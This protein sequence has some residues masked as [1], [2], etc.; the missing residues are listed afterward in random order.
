[1]KD[2]ILQIVPEAVIEDKTPLTVT[3]PATAFHEL[4]YRLRT[5]EDLQF[6][7]LVCMTGMDWGTP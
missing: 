6:D 4:A 5:D 1:M 7:Y 3:V 2:K